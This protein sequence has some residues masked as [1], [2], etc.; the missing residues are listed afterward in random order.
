MLDYIQTQLNLPRGVHGGWSDQAEDRLADMLAK[1][2]RGSSSKPLALLDAPPG[3]KRAG[4]KASSSSS[5]ESSSEAGN[6]KR[7]RSSSSSS[8]SSSSARKSKLRVAIRKL[9]AEV[10]DL[11]GGIVSHQEKKIQFGTGETWA[12]VEADEATFDKKIVRGKLHWEQ[13]CGIV[14]RGKPQT[15]VLHRLKPLA[16]KLRA[17]GPG[18]VRKVEWKPLTAKWLKDRQVILH[19]DSAKGYASKIPGVLHDRVVHKKKAGQGQ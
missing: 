14:E 10:A 13:W 4:K 3:T 15:H 12:D 17:P 18:A 2:K 8:S 7:K 5:S 9:R 11:A 1:Q 6:G 16:S 19:T